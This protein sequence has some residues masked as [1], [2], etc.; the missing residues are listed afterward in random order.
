M[1]TTVSIITINRNNAEGLERTIKSIISQTFRNFE[2]IVI[3]G[4]STDES[5]S[6]IDEYSSEIKYWISEPDKGIFDAMNKGIKQ[7]SGTYC[8]FLN[9]ADCF[10]DENVLNNIFE[11]KEYNNAPYISGHQINDF[12]DRRQ[13]VASPNQKLTLYD[14]YWSTLKHQATFIRR[15]LFD[16]YGMYDD[17]LKIVSDWK[18]FLQTIIFHDEQPVYVDVDIVLFEWFGLSTDEKWKR[19]HDEEKQKTLDELLPKGIQEDYLHFR[20]MSNYSYIA[21]TMKKSSLFSMLVRFMVKIF[22]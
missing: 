14:F 3:D 5:V 13:K 4:A 10:F 22:K 19:I 11:G 2:F 9:S 6:V 18:F 21:D 16:K 20:E 15:D 7:A 17:T 1:T 8:Y 12:G